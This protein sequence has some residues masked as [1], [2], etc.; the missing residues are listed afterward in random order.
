MGGGTK[1]KNPMFRLGR[2]PFKVCSWCKCEF[3]SLGISRHW[4]KCPA[5]PKSKE[6][7]P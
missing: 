7:I 2:Q 6:K 5:K 3:T 4:D 1:V